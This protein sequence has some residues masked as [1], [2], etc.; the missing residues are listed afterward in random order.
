MCGHA[1]LASAAILYQTL[2]NSKGCRIVFHALENSLTVDLAEPETS[3]DDGQSLT[4]KISMEVPMK[5]VQ[6]LKTREEKSAVLKMLESA[7]SCDLE[8]LFVGISNTEDVLIELTPDSFKDI[9]YGEINY[10]ALLEWD[11]YYRGVI[12]CCEG[13]DDSKCGEEKNK[14][15]ACP[16]FLSRFF[17]PKAG[18]NKDPVRVSAHRVLAPY[19]SQKLN[20]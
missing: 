10:K 1:T 11:G 14:D 13:N 17:V 8:P 3:D 4:T 6:E 15:S 9:G 2:P 18:V 12:V 7:F 5:A 20:N 16:D 19:F